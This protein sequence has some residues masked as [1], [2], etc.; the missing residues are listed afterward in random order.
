MAKCIKSGKSRC[1]CFA[2]SAT[3]PTCAG[4]CW[5]DIVEALECKTADVMPKHHPLYRE[6]VA[7]ATR[8]A[9]QRADAGGECNSKRASSILKAC[10]GESPAVIACLKAGENQ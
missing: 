6:S 2:E 9:A 5:K 8:E 7:D 4:A 1:A 3:M 10:V